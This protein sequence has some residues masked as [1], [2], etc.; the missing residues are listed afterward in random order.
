MEPA[1]ADAY[2]GRVLRGSPSLTSS[3]S[4]CASFLMGRQHEKAA[5]RTG[6]QP[7]RG[8]RLSDGARCFGLLRRYTG[9]DWAKVKKPYG[10]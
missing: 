2:F 8:R 3:G 1:D 10:S 6:V 4:C 5:S 7:R 9:M